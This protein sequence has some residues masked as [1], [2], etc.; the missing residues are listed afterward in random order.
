MNRIIVNSTSLISEATYSA[1]I[2]VCS[3]G[4]RMTTLPI[5]EMIKNISK[6]E[7]YHKLMLDLVSKPSSTT[8]G[9]EINYISIT[10]EK[11]ANRKVPEKDTY[12]I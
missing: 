3:A 1:L 9:N 5:E 4:L 11:E 10:T 7:T 8:R 12:F 6:N 2:G